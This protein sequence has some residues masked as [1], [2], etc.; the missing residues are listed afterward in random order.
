MNTLSFRKAIQWTLA[1]VLGTIA[2]GFF[3]GAAF[4]VPPIEPAGCANNTCKQIQYYIICDANKQP[5]LGVR[6]NVTD[7]VPCAFSGRCDGGNAKTCTK[8]DNP[9]LLAPSDIAE[10]CF[11]SKAPASWT[12]EG[13]LVKATGT[14][15]ATNT[16]QYTCP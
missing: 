5:S 4:A 13:T 10:T 14:L 8:S 15:K 12:V 3:Y 9:L 6:L 7:C 11:C 2:V 16:N 1:G